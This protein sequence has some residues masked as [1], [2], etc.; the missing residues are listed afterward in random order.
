MPA[1]DLNEAI[2][3]E[4]NNSERFFVEDPV[5][6]FQV[7]GRVG[8]KNTEKISA[9][10][11]VVGRVPSTILLSYFKPLESNP[12]GDLM[13]FLQAQ[14]F[15]GLNLTKVIP[16]SIAI[17]NIIKKSKSKIQ[18]TIVILEMSSMSS[19]LNIYRNGCWS[20]PAKS[21]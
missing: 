14:D 6:D 21:I 3:I 8:D 1:L 13:K 10:V 5:F 2:K 15:M 12:F 4:V 17:E 16:I 19:E 9:M 18:E 11:A 7:I 20:F